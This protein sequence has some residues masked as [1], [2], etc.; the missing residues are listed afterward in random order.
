M[1]AKQSIKVDD[2]IEYI[3]NQVKLAVLDQ[4]L[5]GDEMQTLAK[6]L[7]FVKQIST[8]SMLA[9][10]PALLAKEMTIGVLRNFSS[11]AIGLND[12][13]DAETMAK[14]YQKLITIDKKF[15]DEF[16]MIDKLNHLYRMANMDIS[17]MPK[18][19][20]ADRWGY[21]KGLGR[22]MFMT[23][24]LGDYYNR[25]AILLAK[26]IK[27]GSYDAHSMVDGNLRYDVKKDKRFEYYFKHR[28]SV[29][30]AEGNYTIKKGDVRYNTQRRLYLLTIDQMNREGAVTNE[31]KLTEKSIIEKAYSH[32]DRDSIKS[33]SDQMY[34]AY[35]KDWQAQFG[36][37]LMGIAFMQ[38][39][40]FWP[41]KMKF[42][43]GKTV[44][45]KD[46]T[47][48][49][50]R[51]QRQTDENGVVLKNDDGTD[52]LMWR[53][54]YID[55]EGKTVWK[56]TTKNTGDPIIVWEGT[57]QEGVFVSLLYT[58]QDIL[59]W[60]TKSLKNNTLRKNRAMFALID[61]VLMV[62]ILKIMQ[63]I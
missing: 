33:F 15:S 50:S 37:T 34:G 6:G 2:Q 60:D 46:S 39:L 55:D 29:K 5:I 17:T 3:I 48:G 44:D 12:E 14:A 54:T 24:T 42:W 28:E 43:F 27:E 53:E 18:K 25:M 47:I 23:S 10:R 38:F 30:D 26:M 49:R 51:Q 58:I 40:T 16:N 13:F 63:Q 20:Q 11:A 45:G 62:L 1:G 4:P 59:R 9:F 57:P 35:D 32:Q 41:S 22:F 31:K 52:V 7:G 21:H 36:N 61:G 19:V 56:P 8:I